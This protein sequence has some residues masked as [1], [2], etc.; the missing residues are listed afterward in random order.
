MMS[1]LIAFALGYLTLMTLELFS[2]MGPAQ[3]GAA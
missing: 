2:A 1:F 3:R